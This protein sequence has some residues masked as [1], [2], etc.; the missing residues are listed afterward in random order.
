MPH[1]P[2]LNPPKRKGAD[3]KVSSCSLNALIGGNPKESLSCHKQSNQRLRPRKRVCATLW[4]TR[5]KYPPNISGGRTPERSAIS[6][7]KCI[8]GVSD[9][10]LALLQSFLNLALL[11]NLGFDPS[12]LVLFRAHDA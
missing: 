11:F 5:R 9:L 10:N 6:S 3:E 8:M 12:S 7:R 2:N 1:G 4:P